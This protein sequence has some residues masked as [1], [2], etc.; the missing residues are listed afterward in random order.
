MFEIKYN[1]KSE[2]IKINSF[3]YSFIFVISNMWLY[4]MHLLLIS[5]YSSFAV[6][7]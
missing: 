1:S 6:K 3:I 2:K 7:A 4:I 5:F